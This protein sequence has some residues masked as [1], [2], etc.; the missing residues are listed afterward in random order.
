MRRMP[1]TEAWAID[2]YGSAGV[3]MA[4]LTAPLAQGAM[5]QA[6]CF[7][8]AP[9]GRIGRHPATLPQLFA[10]LDG[11]GRVSGDD[12]AEGA[13]S[14]GEA[15]FWEAGED[16]ETRTDSGLTAIVIESPELKLRVPA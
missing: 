10:A 5:F 1:F 12:D 8:L 2:A 15:V 6:A 11:S 13:I 7:R 14:A 16:H 9:G 4:P 3:T